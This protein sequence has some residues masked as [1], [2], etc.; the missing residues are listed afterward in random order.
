MGIN[1]AWIG[2]NINEIDNSVPEGCVVEQVA[3]NVRHGSRYPD[4]GAYAQWTALYAKVY[5]LPLLR[6]F[7]NCLYPP[8]RERR[9]IIPE[10]PTPGFIGQIL[11]SK[12]SRSKT[13]HSQPPTQTS[14]S[15]TPGNQSSQTPLYKFPKKVQPATKKPMIW[16]TPFEPSKHQ[17]FL[18]LP[19]IKA[20]SKTN[21]T[22]T[23]DIRISTPTANPSYPGQISTPASSKPRK[24]SCEDF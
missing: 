16:A 22:K 2:P 23:K 1:C 14:N 18:P 12:I 13:Q 11:T 9:Q 7:H 24:I 17:L 15:S 5:P 4:S 6:P 8:E 21:K 19:P 3:Y 10:P 20:K